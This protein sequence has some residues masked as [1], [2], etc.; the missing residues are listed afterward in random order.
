M[1]EKDFYHGKRTIITGG[2]GFIGSNLAIRLAA[3]GAEVTIIDSELP[4]CGGNR[5]NLHP[6]ETEIDWIKADIGATE[7]FSN[8][9]R[10]ADFVF[11]LAGEI[12]HSR[13]MTEPERDLNLNTIAQLRFL[14]ACRSLCPAA[15]I[16]YASTR[17]VYG[18]PLYLPVDEN[19]EIQPVDFNGVHKYAAS[20]Y[21]LLM[22]SRGDLDCA[23]LR[24]SNVY[25]PRMALRLP[26]QGFLGV[27]LRRA[28]DGVPIQIFGDGMQ[29]RDPIHVEDVV[30]AFLAT[31]SARSLASRVFNV[32]GPRPLALRHI[33][34]TVARIGGN[35]RT[36]L[37]MVPFPEHLRKLDIGSYYTDNSR[38]KSELG[39]EPQ[40]EFECGVRE[41][42]AYYHEHKRHYLTAETIEAP[43]AIAVAAPPA[44]ATSTV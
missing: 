16:V 41:T 5:F 34:E 2:L 36:T 33:A 44:L 22:A 31:G 4:D 7:R 27:Y 3:L 39:I 43:P 30:R 12:S 26:Q 13:S 14:T 40:I 6:F 15:R 1:N 25:G 19:H 9:L 42:L 38:L 11:N 17:Q 32:G 21:H 18:K 10:G 35:K 8:S 20:Q 23:I 37:E 28:L 24:L 29:L